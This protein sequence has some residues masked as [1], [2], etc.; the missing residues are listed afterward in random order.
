MTSIRYLLSGWSLTPHTQTPYLVPALCAQNSRMCACVFIVFITRIILHL[1]FKYTSNKKL[2]N[3]ISH[4]K[5]SLRRTTANFVYL[6]SPLSLCLSRLFCVSRWA[7]DMRN[8]LVSRHTQNTQQCATNTHHLRENRRINYLWNYHMNARNAMYAYRWG[9]NGILENE[10]RQLIVFLFS[11][12]FFPCLLILYFFSWSQSV[13]I[14]YF[15]IYIL[16]QFI[17]NTPTATTTTTTAAAA[18]IRSFFSVYCM[19]F[20]RVKICHFIFMT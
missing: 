17:F 10:D 14:G 11:F 6:F 4:R 5:I 19:R 15:N 9:K 16:S 18:Q 2:R 8:E 12:R 3:K 1:P 13:V 20:M 7:L